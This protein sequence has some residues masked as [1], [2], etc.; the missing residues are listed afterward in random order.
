MSKRLKTDNSNK[1]KKLLAVSIATLFLLFVPFTPAHSINIYLTL[2]KTTFTLGETAIFDILIEILSS[3]RIPIKEINLVIL[4]TADVQVM[5]VRFN[6]DGSPISVPT[7]ATVSAETVTPVPTYSYGAFYEYAYGYFGYGYGYVGYGKLKYRV[8]VDTSVLGAGDYVAK[9][10]VITGL[11][12][13]SQFFTSAKFTVSPPPVAAPVVPPAA[14][15]APAPEEVQEAVEKGE[16]D[17]AARQLLSTTAEAAADTLED[18][19]PEDAGN[20]MVEMAKLN[21]QQTGQVFSNLI[22]INVTHATETL[23]DVAEEAPEKVIDILDATPVEDVLRLPTE[24]LIEILVEVAVD[25]E[26][27]APHEDPEAVAVA[28]TIVKTV[29]EEVARGVGFRDA[30]T[31]F[32]GTPEPVTAMY[33]KFVRDIPEVTAHLRILDAKPAGIVADVPPDKY[34]HTYFNITL[35][36]A[37]AE[38]VDVAQINFKVEKTW[39]RDFSIKKLGV[40]LYKYDEVLGDWIPL[41]TTLTGEDSV[42]YYYVSSTPKLST[43]AVTGATTAPTAV[44]SYSDLKISP[45]A[46]ALGASVNVSANITNIGAEPTTR[47]ITIS[48]DNV[49]ADSTTISLGAGES[50][51]VSFTITPTTIGNHTVRIGSLL[52][53]FFVGLPGIQTFKVTPAVYDVTGVERTV[54]RVGDVISISAFI[55]NTVPSPLDFVYLVQIKNSKGE[56]VFLAATPSSIEAEGL[57]SVTVEYALDKPDTYTIEVFVWDRLIDPTPLSEVVKIQIEVRR[58]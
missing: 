10:V 27:L 32:F 40:T 13:P 15:P 45:S 1:R 47:V 53:T 36:G 57:R 14:P 26:I 6:P 12:A 7:G 22:E 21:P 29:I 3:E 23:T 18:V 8:T 54:F 34:V 37:E 4:T 46:I 41:P 35:T 51:I 48:L 43:F 17:R 55:E 25:V 30:W 28:E 9:A 58:G 42:Y 31:R 33:I 20:V 24:K 2:N 44:L 38:D 5:L 52:G 11:V 56:V 49:Y 39:A 16:P 19:N 50:T